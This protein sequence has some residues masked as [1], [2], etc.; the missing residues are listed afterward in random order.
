MQEVL[1]VLCLGAAALFL[2][3][4]LFLHDFFAKRRPDVPLSNLVRRGKPRQRP[5]DKSGG[6][7]H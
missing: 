2:L 1:V 3:H 4:K 7:C 5:A 6:G